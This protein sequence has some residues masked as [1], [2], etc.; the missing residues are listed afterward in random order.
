MLVLPA[1]EV[2]Y[3]PSILYGHILA[4]PGTSKYET[5]FTVSAKK[6]A[7][8]TLHLFGDKGERIEASFVDGLGKSAGTG[9]SF[10]F[11]MTSERPVI[12]RLTLMPEQTANDVAVVTGWA[13]FE[14]SEDI[15][16]AAVVRIT[17]PDGKLINRHVIASERPPA[18]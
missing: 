18:G 11:F 7:R 6:E 17:T 4:G 13:T 12:I 2:R 15:D 1:K 9:H 8:A 3:F 10:E 5:I 16:V 14:S